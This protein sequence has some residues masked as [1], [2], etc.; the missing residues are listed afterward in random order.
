MKEEQF[1]AVVAVGFKHSLAVISCDSEFVIEDIICADFLGAA[2]INDDWESTERAG[3]D[4]RKDFGT[5]KVT[6]IV[7]I[8]DDREQWDYTTTWEK[9]A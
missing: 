8:S 9:I 1:E 2:I 5:Y 4:H 6:G 7:T 3:I